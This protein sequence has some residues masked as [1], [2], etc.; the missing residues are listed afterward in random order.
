MKKMILLIFNLLI[1]SSC[2]IEG[3]IYRLQTRLSYWDKILNTEEQRLFIE[4]KFDELGQIIDAKELSDTN[5]ANK[6]R[7]LHINEA[8][9]SFDGK[10]TAHF[11]Y[12]ILLR[13]LMKFSYIDFMKT[14]DTEEQL[15]FVQ[16]K[17]FTNMP[18]DN[19][20]LTKV[21]I[22]AKNEY[23]VKYFNEVE[24][25]NYYRHIL[26]PYTIYSTVYDI[27]AFLGRYRALEDFLKGDIVFA[28]DPFTLINMSIN[29]KKVFDRKMGK[30]E[31]KRWRNIKKRTLLDKL[32]EEQF[33]N[34]IYYNILPEM[35]KDV[36]AL[37][38]KNVRERF[39]I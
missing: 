18:F 19:K 7:E 10:Q 24:I 6:L 38:I 30:K 20:N 12:N 2:A 22:N 8:I 14:L 36:R 31:L 13:D 15:L 21:F 32:S 33:L 39:N 5:F 1:L 23:G 17:E 3:E 27:L 25:L 28:L 11:F 16:T 9:M 29:S 26:L 35:D 4:T 34:I 37:T